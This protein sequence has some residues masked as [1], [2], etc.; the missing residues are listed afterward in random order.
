VRSTPTHFIFVASRAELSAGVGRPNSPR[1][2]EW[3]MRHLV[4]EMRARPSPRAHWIGIGIMRSPASSNRLRVPCRPPFYCNLLHKAD[5]HHEMPIAA[6]WSAAISPVKAPQP[7]KLQFWGATLAPLVNFSYT[8]PTCRLL[9]HTYT[10]HF[11]VSHAF[12]LSTRPAR[13]AGLTG[14][15]LRSSPRV[16]SNR[17]LRPLMREETLAAEI[18]S[19]HS[20][21]VATNNGTTRHD[22]VE[23]CLVRDCARTGRG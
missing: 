23:E 5:A 4:H 16:A 11:D 19:A 14:L 1:R 10:S 20:L 21:P 8:M 18:R 15:H 12:M 3:P 6:I 22:R 9:G 2:S 17:Q 7:L 13:S